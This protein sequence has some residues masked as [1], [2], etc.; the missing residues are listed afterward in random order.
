MLISNLQCP[1]QSLSLGTIAIDSAVPYYPHGNAVC[2][3][4]CNEC[5]LSHG[6]LRLSQAVVLSVTARASL[7]TDPRMSGLPIRSK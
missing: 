3:H 5:R 7:S 2:D 4:S 6:V 1:Q